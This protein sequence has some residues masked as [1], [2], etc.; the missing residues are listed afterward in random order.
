MIILHTFGTP[1]GQ[2]R[3]RAVNR[4]KHMGVYDP[5]TANDWKSSVCESANNHRGIFLNSEHPLAV[6]MT[7]LFCAPKGMQNKHGA[8]KK[9]DGKLQR[10]GTDLELT[11]LEFQWMPKKPDNDN[12]EKATFDAL[13]DCGIW[14]DDARI[15]HNVTSKVMIAERHFTGA[16]IKIAEIKNGQIDLGHC[17]GFDGWL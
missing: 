8:L 12:I 13:S 16:I 2:P 9:P 7:V 4:G 5:G 6:W 17:Q 14:A 15:V 11:D 3:S 10:V 1:K